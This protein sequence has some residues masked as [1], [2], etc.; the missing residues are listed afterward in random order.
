M[1]LKEYVIIRGPSKFDLSTAFF[2]KYEGKRRPVKFGVKDTSGTQTEPE[3]VELEVFINLLQWED[4][5]GESW[6]FKGWLFG[7]HPSV[8]GYFRTDRRTGFVTM[9]E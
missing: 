7:S 5:S 3:E 4:G 8:S 6:C 2:D 1:A 9:R